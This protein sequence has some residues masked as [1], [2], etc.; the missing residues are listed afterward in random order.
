MDFLY[1]VLDGSSPLYGHI[2]W[3][4]FDELTNLDA[5]LR[6]KRRTSLREGRQFLRGYAWVT[7]CPAELA[8]RLGGASA[9]DTNKR[10]QW[11]PKPNL[12]GHSVQAH[13]RL[14]GVDSLRSST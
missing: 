11:W 12:I 1:A 4:D 13:S 3:D 14:A 7:V 5:V 6:R 9:A 8:A 2:E 10:E